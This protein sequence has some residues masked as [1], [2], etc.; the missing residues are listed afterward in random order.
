MSD[1]I[2][3]DDLAN[4]MTPKTLI[5]QVASQ[6]VSSMNAWVESRTN[7]VWGET[8]TV[9]ERHDWG[10]TL[11][12]RH[13]DV[14]AISALKV[15]WPGQVQTTIDPTGYFLNPRGRVT[16]FWQVLSQPVSSPL[17]NDYV[18]VS[19]THGVLSVPEDLKLAVLGVSAGFYNFATNG[20]KDVSSAS[21]GSYKLEY[22]AKHLIPTRKPET[23]TAEAN[24]SIIDMYKMRKS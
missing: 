4:Y 24:W 2:T 11:W 19:Y 13:Q 12:L 6:V 3:T 18:E 17:Y 7:R 20:Q 8:A 1:I 14:I 22:G 9:V 10:R 16:M 23:V 21:V 15:G 5:P